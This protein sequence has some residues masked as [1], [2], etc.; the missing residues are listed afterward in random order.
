MVVNEV[1]YPE[2]IEAILP[3]KWMTY[4]EVAGESQSCIW[5][6]GGVCIAIRVPWNL[7][8]RVPMG[9][10]EKTSTHQYNNFMA[11]IERYRAHPHDW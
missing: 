2:V 10:Q 3:A 11:V 9:V 4:T 6:A 7:V 5:L 1:V 8:C